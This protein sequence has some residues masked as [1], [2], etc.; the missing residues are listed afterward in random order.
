MKNFNLNSKWMVFLSAS[1]ITLMLVAFLWIVLTLRNESLKSKEI[2]DEH[3]YFD[4]YTDS[5]W[6]L[7]L[8][9]INI[10]HRDLSQGLLVTNLAM[11]E[12]AQSLELLRTSQ[13]SRRS[14]FPELMVLDQEVNKDFK[15]FKEVISNLTSSKELQNDDQQKL[16][17]LKL[18]QFQNKIDQIALK[19]LI[20]EHSIHFR[21]AVIDREQ[22]TIFKL[23]YIISTLI[24]IVVVIILYFLYSLR[25][26]SLRSETAQQ[27]AI[28]E[29]EKG[30]KI[31][32]LNRE[33]VVAQ[34]QLVQSA[35]LASLGEMAAGIAHELNN[36]LYVI[37]GFNERIVKTLSKTHP[38]AYLQI[39][40]YLDDITDGTIRMKKII[41]NLKDFSRKSSHTMELISI[42]EVIEKSLALTH[43]QLALG[44]IVVVT[45]QFLDFGAVIKGDP[46]KLMQ[47]FINLIM[48]AKDAIAARPDNSEGQ[49][50]ISTHLENGNIV[51]EL[52][53][54][55]VGMSVETKSKIFD[56]FFTTKEI[57]KGTGLGGSISYGIIKEHQGQIEC[58]STIGVGTTIKIT[59]PRAENIGENNGKR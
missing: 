36:P 27:E 1:F 2:F 25:G 5:I 42:S 40:E 51:I 47:V 8:G 15:D 52:Q 45:S 39:K 35:K 31:A 41:G 29:R 9:V 23:V 34:G 57:G 10:V 26:E 28:A 17:E 18:Q 59:L 49:I 24:I 21:L 32:A 53:D 37:G 44:N 19:G 30:D 22:K 58:F 54:N 16:L 50:L 4:N 46:N 6:Q 13:L 43:K 12:K 56:A 14:E 48:N 7:Q 20:L 3:R 38:E 33:L 11:I 55:G